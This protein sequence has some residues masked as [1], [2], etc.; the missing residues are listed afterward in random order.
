MA[1]RVLHTPV[2][3]VER[4]A[5]ERSDGEAHYVRLRA[6]DWCNVVPLTDDGQVVLIRQHRW[7]VD[8]PVLEIPGGMVDEGEDPAVAALRELREETGYGGGEL[9]ELGWVFPNPAIQD[10]RCF[11]YAV[12]GARVI[13]ERHLDPGEDIAIELRAASELPD[14]VASEAFPHAL[15]VVS[16]QRV[17]ARGLHVR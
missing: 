2:F 17:I 1:E 16:V 9:I 13:G 7:G 15:A 8:A 11:L 10:N 6:P 5:V 14:L 12:R 3:D 4:F